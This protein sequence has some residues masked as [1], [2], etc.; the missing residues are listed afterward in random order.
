VSDTAKTSKCCRSWVPKTKSIV[1][2]LRCFFYSGSLKISLLLWTSQMLFA[3]L[4]Y[5]LTRSFLIVNTANNFNSS[6]LCSLSIFNTKE[7]LS[8]METPEVLII[9]HHYVEIFYKWFHLQNLCL[10]FIIKACFATASSIILV[11]SIPEDF[12]QQNK[13]RSLPF[14]RLLKFFHQHFH[15]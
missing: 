13:H 12:V 10:Q 4:F 3:Y 15:Q 11:S 14:V 8:S 1:L 9:M 5:F 7:I 6:S 2:L